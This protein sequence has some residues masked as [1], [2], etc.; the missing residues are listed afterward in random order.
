MSK[1]TSNRPGAQPGNKNAIKQTHR[2]NTTFK[3][4][5]EVRAMLERYEGNRSRL[6][7]KLIIEYFERMNENAKQ[8]DDYRSS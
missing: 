4:S 7:E 3:L 6:V 2:L 5:P 1:Q 8:A